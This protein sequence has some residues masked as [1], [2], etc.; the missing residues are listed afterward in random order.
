MKELT[1]EIT[2]EKHYKLWNAIKEEEEKL[3]ANDPNIAG[4]EIYIFRDS[5]KT[6]WCKQ[7]GEKLLND[8]Y[9][10]EYAYQRTEG[11]SPIEDQYGV[12]VAMDDTKRQHCLLKW[13]GD[14]FCEKREDGMG[15]DWRYSPIDEI[16]SLPIN[17][18][19]IKNYHA[20]NT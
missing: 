12:Y 14:P 6:Y 20:E 18:E 19:E 9:L 3:R 5:F 2:L 8:C 16:L 4:N 15:T 1:P 10:C 17:E 11:K 7:K 13:K